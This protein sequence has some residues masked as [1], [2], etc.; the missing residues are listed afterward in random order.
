MSTRQQFEASA[1]VERQPEIASRLAAYP[2]TALTAVHVY[3]QAQRVRNVYK[4]ENRVLNC[5][6]CLKRAESQNQCMRMVKVGAEA[7]ET[8]LL[9]QPLPFS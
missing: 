8:R 6:V 5:L 4:C 7:E 9:S 2:C 3:I 1:V